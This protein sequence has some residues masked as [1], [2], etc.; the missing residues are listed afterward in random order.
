[1]SVVLPGAAQR[2]AARR[3]TAL[4]F[5]ALIALV[6]SFMRGA[7]FCVNAAVD[8]NVIVQLVPRGAAQCCAVPR[9]V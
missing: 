3:S 9:A 7:A 8:Y 4:H 2:R 5:G 6:S 1:V